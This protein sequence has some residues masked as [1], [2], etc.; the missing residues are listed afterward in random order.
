M[1]DFSPRRKSPPRFPAVDKAIKAR[2]TVTQFTKSSGLSA[3]T[4]YKMQ[5]G[6]TT[7]TLGTIFAVMRYTGL[8]FDEAFGEE[9]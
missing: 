6:E 2:G 7:P 8:S 4:Y 3:M 1:I 9:R 5:S